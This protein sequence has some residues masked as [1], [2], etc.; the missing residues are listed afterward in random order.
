MALLAGVSVVVGTDGLLDNIFDEETA[1]AAT[2]FRQGGDS[3]QAV[4]K[5]LA[6]LA[7]CVTKQAEG[8]TPFAVAAREVGKIRPGGKVD[9]ITVIVAHVV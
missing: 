7:R 9:D 1:A 4:A 3:C 5:Q 2:R 8:N 6:E